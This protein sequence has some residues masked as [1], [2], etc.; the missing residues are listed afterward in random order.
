MIRSKKSF[1]GEMEMSTGPISLE[2]GSI[3]FEMG[4]EYPL[5]EKVFSVRI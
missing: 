4:K 1:A 3:G 2:E 5:S